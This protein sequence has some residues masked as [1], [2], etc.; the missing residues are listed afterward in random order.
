[1]V[2]IAKGVGKTSRQMFIHI[3][4]VLIHLIAQWGGDAALGTRQELFAANWLILTWTLR[5]GDLILPFYL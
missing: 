1:M 3:R 5:L 4:A 2:E